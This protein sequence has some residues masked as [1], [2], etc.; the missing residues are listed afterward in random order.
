MEPRTR[1]GRNLDTFRRGPP[2]IK[3]MGHEHREDAVGG[4]G[5]MQCQ[6]HTH[7]RTHSV[8]RDTQ[9]GWNLGQGSDAILTHVSVAA[10]LIKL[11][12]NDHRLDTVESGGPGKGQHTQ[13]PQ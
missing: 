4:G 1:T 11:M 6:T 8:L 13:C 2:L 7:K 9:G 12:G 5:S 3:L 10:P